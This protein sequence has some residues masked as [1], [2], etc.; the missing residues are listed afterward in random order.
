MAVKYIK[1]P[2]ADI[3]TAFASGNWQTEDGNE[4][5]DVLGDYAMLRYDDSDEPTYVSG[6]TPLTVSQALTEVEGLSWEVAFSWDSPEKVI[7]IGAGNEFH[8]MI[9]PFSGARHTV[10]YSDPADSNKG[11]FYIKNLAG[12]K[13]VSDTTFDTNDSRN[14]WAATLTNGNVAI[15]YS[16][17]TTGIQGIV[18]IAS[19]NGSGTEVT[20][21]TSL[22]TGKSD[23]NRCC[24]L[25]SGN[26]AITYVDKDDSSKGKF[27]IVQEDGTVVKAITTFSTDVVDSANHDCF[28][29]TGGGF[30]IVWVNSTSGNIEFA[31]YDNSGTSVKATTTFITGSGSGVGSCTGASYADGSFFLRGADFGDGQR[32]TIFNAAGTSTVQDATGQF[33]PLALSEK[34]TTLNGYSIFVGSNPLDSNKL[35]FA[36]LDYELGSFL[37]QVDV[38]GGAWERCRYIK[39]TDTNHILVGKRTDDSNNVYQ[40]NFYFDPDQL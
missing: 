37:S 18:Y 30:V 7:D 6:G 21:P 29:L 38:N 10:V 13:V 3:A 34:A 26:L 33:T 32:F 39:L 22:S 27:I 4:R 40:M 1:V 8:G 24:A 2:V 16:R 36:I 15:A 19:R 17:V 23:S 14:I 11:K 5:Y 25:T 35:K 28:E 12:T 20:A 9:A 31:I